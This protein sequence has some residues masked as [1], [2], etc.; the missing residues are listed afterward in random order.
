MI[1]EETG[2]GLLQHPL[3]SPDSVLSDFC[4]SPKLK[5]HLPGGKFRNNPFCGG[6]WGGGQ[7]ATFFHEGIAMLKHYYQNIMKNYQDCA[8]L[9]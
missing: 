8:T 5:S 4:L 7:D 2:F 1:P 6:V 9:S 3:D